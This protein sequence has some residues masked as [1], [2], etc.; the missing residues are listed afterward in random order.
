M[1]SKPSYDQLKIKLL[2]KPEVSEVRI[3]FSPKD[4]N[5]YLEFFSKFLWKY[6]IIRPQ[7]SCFCCKQNFIWQ[8]PSAWCAGFESPLSFKTFFFF[9]FFPGLSQNFTKN[10]SWNSRCADF[11]R[12]NIKILTTR[13]LKKWSE[14]TKVTW[15]IVQLNLKS[16]SIL[17]ISQLLNYRFSKVRPFL[18]SME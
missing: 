12:M 1:I 14:L 17:L 3:F 18:E 9:I 10:Q 15:K 4:K 5:F 6:S 2:S 13:V 11:F 7:R 16:N 8:V